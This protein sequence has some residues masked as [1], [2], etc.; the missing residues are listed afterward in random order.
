RHVRHCRASRYGI[1]AHVPMRPRRSAWREP[2][3]RAKILSVPY[4]LLPSGKHEVTIVALGS[5]FWLRFVTNLR[6]SRA[7]L[8]AFFVLLFVLALPTAWVGSVLADCAYRVAFAYTVSILALIILGPALLVIVARSLT[9]NPNEALLPTKLVMREETIDVQ[10]R[11]GE[12][13]DQ[14]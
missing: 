13:R 4:R 8:T 6:A 5:S 2:A 14:R 1:H 9:P 12:L 7:Y 11:D 10:T 3:N